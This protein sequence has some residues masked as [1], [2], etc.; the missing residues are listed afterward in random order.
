MTEIN[1]HFLVISHSVN[2][3]NSPI[4][5]QRIADQNRKQDPSTG[6]ISSSKIDSTL[7]WKDRKGYTKK[8]EPESKQGPPIQYLTKYTSN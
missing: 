4:K 5:R 3:P 7:K 8:I 6:N 1:T 2:G